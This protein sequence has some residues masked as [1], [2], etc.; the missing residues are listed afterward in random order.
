MDRAP[1][2]PGWDGPLKARARTAWDALKPAL[3]LALFGLALYALDRVLAAYEPGEILRALHRVPLWIVALALAFTALGYAALVGYDWVAFRVVGRPL[4]LRTVAVPSFVSFAV[5]ASAPGSMVAGGGVRYRMYRP[6]G[7]SAAEAAAVALVDA[8]SW[9]LGLFGLAGAALLIE[10]P[11]VVLGPRL[12]RL[13]G[14]ALVSAAGAYFVLA[15]GHRRALRVR[16]LRLPLPSPR[17][18]LLQLAVSAADWLLAAGAL[19]ALVA[20]VTS[21]PF[22]PFLSAFLAAQVSS[23]LLPVPGGLGVFEAVVLLLVP[24]AASHPSVLAALLLYRVI[25][26]LLP[27]LVAGLLAFGLAVGESPGRSPV[28]RLQHTLARLAPHG[29][30]AITFLSG[31]LLFL[32]GALPRG[33]ERVAWLVHVLPSGLVDASQF[34]ASVVGAAL[35]VVAWGLERGVRLAYRAALVLFGSGILLAVTRSSD[36]SLS[37]GMAGVLVL[38]LASRSTFEAPPSELNTRMSPA[39]AFAV[40]APLLAS[41][42]LGLASH[43]WNEVR[44]QTWWRFTLFGDA[45]AYVRAAVGAGVGLLLAALV[46]AM[47]RGHPTE[48]PERRRRR[49]RASARPGV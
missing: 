31:A 16:R 32:T 10:P 36:T 23:F 2:R 5:S 14:A 15:S 18:A 6:L 35:L 27:L 7:I 29:L 17:L 49:T 39:W 33:Q 22:A 37:A 44:G 38:L 9:L 25:Y 13:L 3:H 8:A 42:W 47:S 20:S 43:R 11:A 4:R 34:L 12:G 30:A 41:L 28:E 26:Y 1:A 24:R 40:G 21:V 46:R 19:Y 45:P 48:G